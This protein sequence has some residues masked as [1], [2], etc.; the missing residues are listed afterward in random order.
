MNE[1]FLMS[2][3]QAD[4]AAPDAAHDQ[5]P[6]QPFPTLGYT[7]RL[8]EI[9]RRWLLLASSRGFGPVKLALAAELILGRTCES[10]LFSTRDKQ[11]SS[12]TA[13]EQAR[14]RRCMS[15]VEPAQPAAAELIAVVIQWLESAADHSLMTLLD[16]DY[17]PLLKQLK[18]PPAVLYLKGRRDLLAYPQ[19][20]IVGSRRASRQGMHVAK[21]FA[22]ELSANGLTITSGLAQGIDTA[23]HQGSTETRTVAV[24]GCGT[25]MFYPPANRP[26]QV[27]IAN[28]GLLVSEFPPG[29]Q[30]APHHFPKRNRIIAGLCL[31]TLVVEAGVRSGSLHTAMSALE[32]GR[33]VMAIPGS[34]YS[35][36]SRGCHSLIKQGAAL[37]ETATD[38][39]QRLHGTLETYRQLNGLTIDPASI[40]TDD[41]A[42]LR[43]P[44]QQGPAKVVLDALS[45]PKD[46]D[47][48]VANTGLGVSELMQALLSLELDDLVIQEGG[49]YQRAEFELK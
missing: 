44:A 40:V 20:A 11:V 46:L 24:L 28:N 14:V 43:S 47:E 9:Q 38:I 17:P 37:V 31:G 22:R 29:T 48:L 5:S 4:T 27:A 13:V 26:L 7:N 41:M 42:A 30:P 8:S 2:A 39:V 32:L 18:D 1:S 45:A 6:D 33:E 21:S 36:E 12:L 10:S 16:D 49:R 23:A 3:V 15:G 25:D 19:I 35:T 34:I